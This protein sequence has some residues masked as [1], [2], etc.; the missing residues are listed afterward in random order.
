MRITAIREVFEE[1]GLLL[2]SSINK[3]SAL[4]SPLELSQARKAIHSRVDPLTFPSFLASNHL[5]TAP[6]VDHL[7]PFTQW[8]TPVNAKSRFSTR[9]Y[10]AF[11]EEMGEAVHVAEEIELVIS[12]SLGE[13]PISPNLGSVAQIP[14]PTHD[15]HVEILSTFFQAPREIL[16]SFGEGA[17]SLMPPQYYLL[18][19]LADILE[20]PETSPDL[21]VPQYVR[22]TVGKAF[23][24]RVFNPKF[25]TRTVGNDGISRAV[26]M[27]EGDDQYE[28][29]SLG[30]TIGAENARR[31][32]SL[33]TFKDGVGLNIS[34]F[35]NVRRA[36]IETFPYD[37]YAEIH[38]IQ[39][40]ASIQLE[41]TIDVFSPSSAISSKL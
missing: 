28:S 24:A 41:R 25:G 1:T 38:L 29:A 15:D 2:A 30:D 9:F 6:I 23:G 31:H 19:T 22:Q 37:P 40:P 18:S 35:H 10:V 5:S 3:G 16:R 20:K 27:Y 11:L 26:L 36:L 17:I 13:E 33:V 8:I 14:V 12:G 7:I 4:I 39:R 32:R 21:S 34:F